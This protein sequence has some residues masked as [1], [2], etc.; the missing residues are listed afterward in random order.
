MLEVRKQEEQKYLEGGT[1]H[2]SQT[3]LKGEVV[4]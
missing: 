4:K 3:L 2:R 1:G